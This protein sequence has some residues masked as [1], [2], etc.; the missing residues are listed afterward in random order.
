MEFVEYLADYAFL[1]E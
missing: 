1:L